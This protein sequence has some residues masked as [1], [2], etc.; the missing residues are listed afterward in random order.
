VIDSGRDHVMTDTRTVPHDPD[1]K[2]AANPP[3]VD[4]QLADEL[5][6]RAQAEGVELR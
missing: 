6:G 1:R 2:P 4:E 5:L 3:L